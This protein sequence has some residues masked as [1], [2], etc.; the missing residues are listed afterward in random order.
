MITGSNRPGEFGR[1]G[2]KSVKIEANL[3]NSQKKIVEN[4]RKCNKIDENRGRSLK[5]TEI[6]ENQRKSTKTSE[7]RRKSMEIVENY[8]MGKLLERP[9]G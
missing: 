1:S 3:R 6:Y 2:R 7:D 4:L 8:E 5:P 9:N